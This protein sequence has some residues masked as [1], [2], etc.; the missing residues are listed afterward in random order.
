V[1]GTLKGG[2][3]QCGG[4]GMATVWWDLCGGEL[5]RQEAGG[6]KGGK[7]TDDRGMVCGTTGITGRGRWQMLVP[8]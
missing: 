4:K 3:G 5:D 7:L 1:G 8:W 6:R 2:E